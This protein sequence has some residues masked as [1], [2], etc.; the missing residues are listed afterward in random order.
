MNWKDVAI[1]GAVGGAYRFARDMIKV[2]YSTLYKYPWIID[3]AAFL[4]GYLLR[5][6]SKLASTSLMTSAA[7][8]GV[9]DGI[10]RI[11]MKVGQK[12]NERPEV[13]EG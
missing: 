13:E 3:G 10:G 7:I 6:T 11:Y 8:S 12:I 5:K 2:Q 4:A 1:I 9:A